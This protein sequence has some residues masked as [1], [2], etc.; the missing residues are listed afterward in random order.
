MSPRRDLSPVTRPKRFRRILSVVL[1]FLHLGLGQA[2]MG[3]PRR[4]F[5]WIAAALLVIAGMVWG[6]L[7]GPR[8]L[9]WLGVAAGAAVQLAGIV[10]TLLL[11][12]PPVPPRALRTV[13]ISIAMVAVLQI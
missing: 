2:V 8:Y 1:A 7:V 12:A 10:D 11:P 4:G 6:V 3:Y 9:W 13:L 5:M